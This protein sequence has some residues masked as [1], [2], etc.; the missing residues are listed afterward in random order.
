MPSAQTKIN[1]TV[2][3]PLAEKPFHQPFAPSTTVGEVRTDAM[4]E[5]GVVDDPQHQYYL[6]FKGARLENET[7]L[8]SLEGHAEG[9][10]LTLV[11]ELIQG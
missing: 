11:K 4:R 8:G 2:T 1:V 9:L 10:K 3:F 7:E 6:T 5:F